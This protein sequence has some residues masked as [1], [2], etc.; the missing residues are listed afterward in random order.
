MDID[1][2]IDICDL[3]EDCKEWLKRNTHL[4]KRQFLFYFQDVGHDY[5][6]SINRAIE[7]TGEIMEE[8]QIR[9]YSIFNE[10][11]LPS[12]KKLIKLKELIETTL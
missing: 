9:F 7:E 11:D 12:D 1:E 3:E 5:D 4:F 10:K 2:K 6:H 8:Y